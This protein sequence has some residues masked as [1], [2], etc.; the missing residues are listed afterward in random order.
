MIA[1]ACRIHRGN[2]R[3][4]IYRLHWRYWAHRRH[5]VLW[6][7]WVYWS[8]R[9]HRFVQL[10]YPMLERACRSCLVC[11]AKHHPGS[12]TGSYCPGFTGF[13]GATGSTG[14]T[15]FTGDTGFTGATGN[16]HAVQRYN[17]GCLARD[18]HLSSARQCLVSSSITLQ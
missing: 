4:R 3:H 14:F 9:H 11:E 1:W 8:H 7:H 18:L 5:R 17:L 10:L 6:C 12:E 16:F 15:G 13:T 2:R